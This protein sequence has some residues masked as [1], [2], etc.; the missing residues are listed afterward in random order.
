ML[1]V[2]ALTDNKHMFYNVGNRYWND[3]SD[4]GGIYVDEK[5][6]QEYYKTRIL[7]A[8]T[9]MTSEKYLKLVFYFVKACYREEKE[10]ET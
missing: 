3:V 4:I 7:E 2:K 10:K 1:S 9:A 5:K 8:V 6:Q